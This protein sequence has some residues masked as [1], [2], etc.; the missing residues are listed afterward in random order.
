VNAVERVLWYADKETLPQELPHLNHGDDTEPLWPA[1][2]RVSF[3]DV[4]MS[5]R[6]GLP[7]VLK[8]M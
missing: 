5:Y 3:E 6:P 7:A 8:G 4:T 1:E 2:G